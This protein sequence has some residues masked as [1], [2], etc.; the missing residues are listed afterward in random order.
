MITDQN[1]EMKK[2]SSMY[3]P[4]LAEPPR[5][6]RQVGSVFDRLAAQSCKKGGAA[7]PPAR[8]SNRLRRNSANADVKEQ[9]MKKVR[10]TA[11]M[12]KG[13]EFT[14]EE[15]KQMKQQF[16]MIDT[17]GNGVLDKDE[18]SAFAKLYDINPSFVDLAVK[19]FDQNG[20][21][22]LSFDEFQQFMDCAQQI[23]T[24]PR[25]FYKKLFDVMDVDHSGALDADELVEF[26]RI[27][28]IPITRKEAAD[29]AKSMD[30]R[31]SGAIIF[32]DLCHWLGI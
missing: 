7:A 15:V 11:V 23:D 29:V 6:T 5:A 4:R 12:K 21:E 18:L 13:R 8:D 24:K 28:R 2:N 17:D 26:C 19:I 16:E 10:A 31:G 14:E 32:D 9:P 27:M 1:S 20:D 22:C 30:M 3:E 25:I